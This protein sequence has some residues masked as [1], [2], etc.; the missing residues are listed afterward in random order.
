MAFKGKEW[1]EYTLYGLQPLNLDLPLT[2]VSYFEANAYA[3]WSGHRLPTEQESEIFLSTSSDELHARRQESFHPNNASAA[4]GQVWWWTQSQY[5][6]YPGYRPFDDEL[7]EY[8]GKFMC[9]Q[10]VLRG[11]SICT[12]KGHYRHSYRNFYEPSQRWMF[13]GIRLAKDLR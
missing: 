9:N 3:N 6:P 7:G 10:F 2:H 8:N 12:P 5:S 4:V 13:S 1:F 11:G